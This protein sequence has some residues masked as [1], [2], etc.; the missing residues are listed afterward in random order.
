M[1]DIRGIFNKDLSVT[2]AYYIGKGLG[3]FFQFNGEKKVIVGRDNRVSGEETSKAAIK[4]LLE[5]GC[6]VISLGIIATPMIYFSWYNLDA[7]ATVMVT[8]S[9]N[10]AEYNGFKCSLKKKPIFGDAYQKI[11]EI[12]LNEKFKEGSGKES[13]TNIFPDYKEKI[14]SSVSLKKKLKIAIDCGNGTESLFAPTIF[15]ELNCEVVPVFCD[16]DG[17]FPNHQPY[18]QK[19][20]LYEKLKE[21]I[22]GEHCDIGLAF[23]GDGDRLGVYDEKGHFVEADRLA[24]IFVEDIC[25][26]NANKKIVMNTSTSLSVI[27]FIKKLGGDFYLWKTGYPNITEKMDEIKAIFGGEISGHFFFRDKY[28]GFDDALYAGIRVLEILSNQ[29]ETFS[30]IVSKLPRYFET[31]E[32]RVEIP[33]HVDKFALIEKIKEDLKKE[34]QNLE[35]LDFD[36]I[37]FSFNDGWGLIR[38]SNTE[39]LITGRAEGKTPERLN[40]IKEIIKNKL[41]LFKINLNWD[42]Y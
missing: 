10:P 35:I 26:K 29:T 18:P 21:T 41:A 15:S 25:K 12:C 20:E 19:I 3:T 37:R 8:A 27:N 1:Y 32:Y 34:Y 9:H 7:N 38:P 23:D 36:G 16:S 42:N 4:G 14:K 5:T 13:K 28:L 22:L 30:A 24:M 11:K 40:E 2:D 39:P 6:D 31:R 33:K 17:S